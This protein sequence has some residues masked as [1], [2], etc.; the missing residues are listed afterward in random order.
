MN[1]RLKLLAITTILS[2]GILLTLYAMSPLNKE[3]TRASFERRFLYSAVSLDTTIDLT[4]NSFY[5][6]GR[7][8]TKMFL[9]NSTAPFHVLIAD[10][11]SLDTTHVN[12]QTEVDS[13]RDLD[14]FRLSVKNNA[15][16]LFQGTTPRV[17]KGSIDKW[18]ADES[19]G[20]YSYFAMQI[21]KQT[22]GGSFYLNSELLNKQ[23]DGVF[24]LDG[25]MLLSED[26]SSLF[27]V[28]NYRN[29]IVS[30]DTAL[31]IKRRT[32]TI[33]T[34]TRARIQVAQIGSKGK[35]TLSRPP[36]A[37][38]GAVA[39]DESNLY[40]RSMLLA[41]NETIQLFMTN[42]VIDIYNTISGNYISSVYISNYKNETLREFWI[43][44]DYIYVLSGHFLNRYTL[45]RQQLMEHI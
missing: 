25:K 17:L 21:R 18:K 33:D 39:I 29:E 30:F 34:F 12:I 3:M 11:P 4:F 2:I 44:G 27:F 5:Y 40:I 1:L 24:C 15:F 8:G 41:K 45:D 9:G 43:V 38:N 19:L 16:F 31:N 20:D 23:V 32:H 36:I 13:L 10:I 22:I 37:I 6:A 35:S 42:S 7:S 26:N 28:H 14:Q